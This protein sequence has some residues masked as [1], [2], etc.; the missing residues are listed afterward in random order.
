MY[1]EKKMIFIHVCREKIMS[2]FGKKN[3][4]KDCKWEKNE[5]NWSKNVLSMDN[6]TTVFN[7]EKK[8]SFTIQIL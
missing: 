2:E 7:F 4:G 5:K 8:F 6:F 1:W 3:Q